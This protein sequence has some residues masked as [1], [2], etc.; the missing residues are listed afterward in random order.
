MENLKPRT[1][2][3]LINGLGYAA[4]AVV[5]YLAIYLLGRFGLTTWLFSLV[6]EE[7]TFLRLLA[8]PLIAWL[9]LALGGAITGVIGGWVLASSMGTEHRGK[10]IAGSAVAFAGSTGVLIIVFLLLVS[11]IALYNNFTSDRVEQFGILFGLFGLVFGLVTGLVQ[12]FTTVKL[13]HTWRVILASTLGFA[14]GG[15]IAGLLIRWINPLNGLETTPI[16]TTLLLVIA[17]VLPYFVGGGAIGLTYDR[18]ALRTVEAGEPVETAQSPRWQ[19]VV[20][21]ILALFIIVPV[22]N[23]VNKISSFLTIMPANLQSQI[24]P[25]TTGIRWSD[26]V[27][28]PAG[29][30]DFD[31]PSSSTEIAVAAGT[32]HQ[33][34]CS[35]EGIIQYQ[36]GSDPVEQIEFPSCSS[37]PTIALDLEG[38][39]H[40]VWY[41]QEVRDTNGVTNPAS[42]LVES[43]R[44]NG[45]WSEAVIVAQTTG[46]TLSSLSGDADGSM[47]LVWSEASDPTGNIL[48]SVKEN[49]QCSEEDLSPVELAGLEALVGGDT[50]PPGSI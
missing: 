31:L 41:T 44:Q 36:E 26:P 15:I 17:L 39:P 32:E 8:I 25:E 12:A 24:S 30:A 18:I 13:R 6:G 11:F 50:R 37:T 27:P 7:Q 5:G 1:R 48:L 47:I 23:L 28:L 34:W 33:A 21:A 43:V 45:E 14:I 49:Y 35:S 38:T 10:L 3:F 9:M 20:V 42:M 16:L 2:S 40:I 29:S 22:V 4:G 19:I 46:E